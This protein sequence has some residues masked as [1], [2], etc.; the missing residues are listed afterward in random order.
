VHHPFIS[1]AGN[2]GSGKT[3]LTGI[4]AKRLEWEPLYE[5]FAHNPYLDRFYSDMKRWGFHSQMFFLTERLKQHD[6]LNHRKNPVLQ[7]R[8]IYEDAEIFAKN[9]HRQGN[10][11]DEDFAVY[12]GVYDSMKKVLAPPDLIVYLKTSVDQLKKR[13]AKRG[14]E[15]EQDIS[16]KYL[17]SLSYLYDEWTSTFKLAPVLVIDTDDLNIHKKED[18]DGVIDQIQNCL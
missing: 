13:I 17:E 15:F 4:L 18:V 6:T 8:S 7:D 3:T 10:I 12:S 1:I 5:N 14:R 9:L 16:E 2:M 11:P